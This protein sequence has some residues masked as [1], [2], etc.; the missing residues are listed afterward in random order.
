MRPRLF[1]GTL[2]FVALLSTTAFACPFCAPADADLF[3]EVQEA[4]A[5]VLVSRVD[6]QKYKILEVWKGQVPAGKVVIAGEPRGRASQGSKLLLTTAGPPNLPYWSDAPRHLGGTDLAFVKRALTLAKASKAQQWDFAAQHLEKGSSEV[7]TAAY[8]L[9]AAAPLTE[10]QKRAQSVGHLKLVGWARNSNIPQE[11]RA[12][13]LLMCYPGLSQGDAVWLK[14]SLFEQKLPSNSPLLGPYIVAYL[15][16]VGV[17][18]VAEV[19]RR[20]LPA[21]AAPAQTLDVTRALALIGHRTKHPAVKSAIQAV[22]LREVTHPKRGAYAIA[23][24]AVWKD[25]RAASAVEKL[26][27]DNPNT[28]WIKVAAIRYFRAFS[29]P[30]ASAAL[31]RLAQ[32]DANLVSRTTDSYKFSELGIE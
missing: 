12:L 22:F 6:T 26:A 4:Q 13:Y 25:Y 17:P 10:V 27:N 9:L 32:N 8:S 11:R 15:Q 18:G 14:R 3:S 20:F 24:L 21:S 23:P 7:A 2:L 5:V 19:E 30:E 16:T 31:A 1:L 28:V 29:S